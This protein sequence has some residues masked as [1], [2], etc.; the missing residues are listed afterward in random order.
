MQVKS[1]EACHMLRDTT[2]DGLTKREH[3]VVRLA[4]AGLRNQE[5]AERLD[6]TEGTVKLHLHNVYQKLGVNSRTAL[7]AHLTNAE[8]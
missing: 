4:T 7:V 1:M 2:E 5:I 8:R 3:E 6:I